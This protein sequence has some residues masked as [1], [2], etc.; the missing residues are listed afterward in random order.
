MWHYS[1]TY[2]GFYFLRI[3]LLSVINSSI[4]IK[5]TIWLGLEGNN[6]DSNCAIFVWDLSNFKKISLRLIRIRVVHELLMKF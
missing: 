5:P 1:S 2:I 4:S 3:R 6:T